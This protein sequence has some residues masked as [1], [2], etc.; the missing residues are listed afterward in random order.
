[1]PF[2]KRVVSPIRLGR[3][4]ISEEDKF[5]KTVVCNNTLVG[6]LQQLSSLAYFADDLFHELNQECLTVIRRTSRLVRKV[7]HVENQIDQLDFKAVKV[8]K[9][10]FI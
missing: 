2:A 5:E 9:C 6:V 1:M 4:P 7:K 3:K 10:I 8:R